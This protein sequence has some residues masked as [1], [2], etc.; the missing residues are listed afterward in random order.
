MS[1]RIPLNG[2]DWQFK[3]FYGEDWRWRDSHK[4]DTRDTRHWFQGN[5]PGSVHHDLWQNGEI[6][7]PY[8]ERNSLLLEWIPQRTWIYKKSF[9]LPDEL[10]GKR[11]TLHFEG[12]DY[13]AEF[14]LNGVSLG[15]HVGMYT[16]VEFDVTGQ[17][18]FGTENM[19]AVVIE[20]AP[21]EQPQVSRTS[22]VRTHKSRMTYWWDFCPRMIH[23]GI[24]DAVYL[25]ADDTVQIR[26]V[27]VRSRLNADFTQAVVDVAVGLVSDAGQ[28]YV[29][30]T[31]IRFEGQV[32]SREQQRLTLAQGST[33]LSQQITVDAPRLWW[34]NGSGEQ[35]LYEAVVRVYGADGASPLDE[36]V[37]NFGIRDIRFAANEGA[38][39]TTLGY[40]CVVNGQKTYIKGWNWVPLDVLYGVPRPE[41]LDHLLRLVGQAH[42]N[43]LR[44]WGGGLIEREDFYGRCDQLG[45]MVWQ[46]FIQ[47]SSGIENT[48][49][50]D[51]SFI[52][53]M[54]LEAEQIIPRKRY[55]PSLVIWGGGNE[56]TDSQN[57]PLDN[58]HPLLAAL[59]E[60]VKR[61]DPDRYWL[62]TSPT[63]RVFMNAL[64]T[65]ER[66]PTGLHDVH[67][68]WEYQGVEGQYR[69]Y[70]RST[71]LL[72][73]E[74]GVEGVTNLKTLNAIIAPEHQWPATLDNPLWQ[75]L[76]AWWNQ[77]AMWRQVFGEIN[78]IETLVRATQFMQAEG[79]RYAVEADQRRAFQN[80]GTL[81]WQF[82]EP[83]PMA[84]CTSAVDYYG[85]AKPSYY[86]V[87]RAY[88]PLHLSA[89]FPTIAWVGRSA[90]EAEIWLNTPPETAVTDAQLRFGLVGL[91]GKVHHQHTEAVTCGANTAAQVMA[92]NWPFSEASEPV[93]FLDLAL[94]DAD[95]RVI[96][97]N[98][99]PFSLEANLAPFTQ[100]PQ[101][102]LRVETHLEGDAWRV[103]VTNTGV[104]AAVGIWL[105]DNRPIKAAGFLYMDDNHFTLL[106]DE[107]R[108]VNCHWNDIPE[109]ERGLSAAGWNTAEWTS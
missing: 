78:D 109:S 41:K 100:L 1:Q 49:S 68:P 12:V 21:H 18:E 66:D 80:S 27:F 106:P 25:Q 53:R 60:T 56:L 84:T 81:P 17:V 83:Y 59:A 107:S 10:R 26:D 11:L 43:M 73:S 48:P 13:A 36:H 88:E 47:S 93:F 87:A 75:H 50:T 16:P 32:V 6:P 90:F 72:H 101:T 82:N 15:Q 65:I 4:P 79:L 5:V 7:D 35:P 61:L 44:I 64:D 46:E 29:V 19:V 33:T 77:Q 28:T 98:R 3:A 67:G 22:K 105:Q 20:A 69:L 30:E 55:H 57:N 70:N 104:N 97:H 92:V 74:F 91:S 9:F 62:A 102:Q 45:I 23:I 37:I 96:A 8:F 51:H 2:S 95:E 63:G 94:T 31:L 58:Q 39:P 34:P 52:D 99:Y 89:R 42:V 71:S 54:V 85:Q 76:G 38:D 108:V 86:A 103:M 14:F 40:T 24:W